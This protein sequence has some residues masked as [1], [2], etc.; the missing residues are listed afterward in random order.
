MTA[1]STPE[2]LAP[3]PI[4]SKKWPSLQEVLAES[5]LSQAAHLFLQAVAEK[6]DLPLRMAKMALVFKAR[7]Q[8]QD[9]RM[10]ARAA[11]TLAPEDYRIR[12]LCDWETR[13]EAPL[14]HFGIIHD[15]TRNETYARAL[16]HHVR[17]GMTVFEIGTG[18][19]ILAMLAVRAGAGHV[20]TC[21]RRPEVAAAA[22]DIIGKNG[23]ADRITVIA[24]DAFALQLG[25]DIPRRAELF[26]AEL[27]DNALV[28]E[29]VLPLT[30][31]ARERFLLPDAILLP[32]RIAAI[33]C[34][35]SGRGHRDSYR[36][37]SVMGFD[38]TPFNRFSPLELSAGKG[39]GT[40]EALSDAVELAS[41]DLRRTVP[42]EGSH[43]LDLTANRNGTAEGIMRWLRLDFGHGIVFENRPPLHSSWD[44]LLHVLPESREVTAGMR[45]QI[46][47]NHSHDRLFLIP[48]TE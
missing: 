3:S 35:V 19:G 34:L 38:L 47:V 12:V 21:E 48:Q 39:G 4:S 32:Q 28:G 36:M 26:V 44:P 31:L 29:N 25:V 46:E 22:R 23:M 11:R 14:W 45:I 18:T 40:F 13:R 30:E 1:A 20:Y 10:L 15:Q 27:V 8:R 7:T 41:F 9:A 37:D 24:K 33:G 17:P 42:T 43:L 2:K 6:H 16:N 5:D